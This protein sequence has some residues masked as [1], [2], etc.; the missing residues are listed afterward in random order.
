MW[1]VC[2]V[3]CRKPKVTLEVERIKRLSAINLGVVRLELAVFA[4]A[5]HFAALF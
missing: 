2:I 3:Y 1:V 4:N 5:D